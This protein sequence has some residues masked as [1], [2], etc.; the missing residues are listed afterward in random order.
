MNIRKIGH[1]C[2]LI[3]IGGVRILTDPG[4]FSEGQNEV[5]GLRAVLITHE[6]ADHLHVESLKQVIEGNP[7]V[8]IISN[9]AVGAILAT[10]GMQHEVISDK[11]TIEVDGVTIEAFDCKHEEIFEGFGQ[12]VIRAEFHALPEAVAPEERL[13][14]APQKPHE[15]RHALPLFRR[16]VVRLR[17]IQRIGQPFVVV[18]LEMQTLV[19]CVRNPQRDWNPANQVIDG[20]PACRMATGWEPV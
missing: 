13:V 9:A 8:R 16:Q 3:E 18:M 10:A 12:V 4:V 6:H 2:L 17:I 7:G 11:E 19:A 15:G 5:E 1:C 20:R 14:E